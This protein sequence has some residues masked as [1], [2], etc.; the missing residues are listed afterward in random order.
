MASRFSKGVFLRYLG[1]CCDSLRSHGI[2]SS[3]LPRTV[4][5]GC[6]RESVSKQDPRPTSGPKGMTS[7]ARLIHDGDNDNYDINC[8]ARH[9]LCLLSFARCFRNVTT[10]LGPVR[11]SSREYSSQRVR[12]SVAPRPRSKSSGY[13]LIA[14]KCPS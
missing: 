1:W 3:G 4:G 11:T 10:V 9:Y 14:L 12:T 13:F 7:H 6:K 8:R 2:K 5:L